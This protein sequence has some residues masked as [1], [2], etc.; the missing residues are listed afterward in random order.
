MGLK[1]EDAKRAKGS[2]YY[3]SYGSDASDVLGYVSADLHHVVEDRP[4]Y[5]D[6]TLFKVT[7]IVEEV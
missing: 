5:Y 2:G 1:R 6:G 3:S 4:N 7:I